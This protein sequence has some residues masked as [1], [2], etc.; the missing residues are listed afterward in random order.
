MNNDNLTDCSEVVT[1]GSLV[2]A[3]TTAGIQRGRPFQLAK[4]G[5]LWAD[6]EGGGIG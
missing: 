3:E 2:P 1:P 5:T 4:A 6:P